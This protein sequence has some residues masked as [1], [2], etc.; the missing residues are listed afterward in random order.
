MSIADKLQ[1]VA[2]NQQRVYDAGYEKSQAECQAVHFSTSVF[3]NGTR[4]MDF[5]VPF[6]PD[7]F[8][9]ICNDAYAADT[10]YCYR[11]L[12]VD[13]RSAC[14][15]E[16]QMLATNSN[17]GAGSLSLSPGVISTFTRYENGVVTHEILG[18]QYQ[19][20]YFPRGVKYSVMAIKYPGEDGATLL[21]EQ[22]ENLPDQVP[23]GHSGQ[24]IYYTAAV[25]RYMTTEEWE[26][27]IATKPNWTFVMQ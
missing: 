23:S 6:E 19:S 17:G 27:L 8:A 14:K 21:R 3:G 25:E 11:G 4:R 16:G 22:I 13:F 5:P 12:I 7:V 24:L 26:N 15:F 9:F 20:Y 10:A 2:E 18:T 1:T